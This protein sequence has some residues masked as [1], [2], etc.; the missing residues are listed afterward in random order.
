MTNK[1]EYI[2]KNNY[3]LRTFHGT[4]DYTEILS[5]WEYL[6]KEKLKNRK[7]V[8]VINDF[9]NAKLNMEIDDLNK[10][11][12]LFKKNGNIFENLKL[13]VIMTSPDNIVFPIFAQIN[14]P[15]KIKTFSTMEGAEKWI[16]NM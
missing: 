4:F 2:E 7:Y 11:L 6:I 12:D 3:L 10:L 5:S 13:A 1:I 9:S 14:F 15:F 8:G 16:L